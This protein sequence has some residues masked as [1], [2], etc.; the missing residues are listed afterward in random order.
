MLAAHQSNEELTPEMLN[1]PLGWEEIEEQKRTERVME[2]LLSMTPAQRLARDQKAAVVI[3]RLDAIAAK[4]GI[5]SM[6]WR[7]S[8]P[9]P[10]RLRQQ[11]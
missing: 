1:P 7:I 5:R 10:R 2:Y 6:G 9:S 3:E 8:G 4:F 11:Q